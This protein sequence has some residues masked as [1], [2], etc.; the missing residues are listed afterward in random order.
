M[1]QFIALVLVG[2]MALMPLRVLASYSNGPA[3][4]LEMPCHSPEAP[5]PDEAPTAN[6]G[7]LQGCCGGFL[8]AGVPHLIDLP[9]AGQR[10]Q[11]GDDVH[12]GFVPDQLD[13]PPVFL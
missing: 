5:Q 12:A 2:L 11:L 10:P 9:A 7:D 13:P 8:G 4:M 1:R 3:E 6:C